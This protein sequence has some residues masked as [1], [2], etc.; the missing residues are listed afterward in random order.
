[1]GLVV[2]GAKV[3]LDADQWYSLWQIAVLVPIGILVYT[4]LLRITYPV[5]FSRLI[6]L[7]KRN[8]K[9]VT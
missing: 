1:M 9:A 7:V 4:L 8:R 3:L 5:G 6:G 2:W